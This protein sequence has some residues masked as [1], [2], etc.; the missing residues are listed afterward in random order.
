MRLGI[1]GTFLHRIINLGFGGGSFSF[2]KPRGPVYDKTKWLFLLLLLFPSVRSSSSY[3][4][5]AP[6]KWWCLQ[7]NEEETKLLLLHVYSI[8]KTIIYWA[9]HRRQRVHPA[10]AAARKK[11]KWWNGLWQEKRFSHFLPSDPLSWHGAPALFSVLLLFR[12]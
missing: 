3:D 8:P 11:Q 6:G 4:F 12:R 5:L 1:R 9:Q 2:L 10:D 7:A